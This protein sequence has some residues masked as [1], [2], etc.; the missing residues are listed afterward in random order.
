VNAHCICNETRR[1]AFHA[2]APRPCNSIPL[3]STS[4]CGGTMFYDAS[5][6][7]RVPSVETTNGYVIGRVTVT[8]VTRGTGA[9][10]CNRC[11]HCE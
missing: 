8:H 11:E 10:C 3:N 6:Q 9:W 5:A 2:K 7:R 1:C 4:P